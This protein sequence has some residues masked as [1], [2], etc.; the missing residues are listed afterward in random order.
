MNKYTSRVVIEN[1]TIMAYIDMDGNPVIGQPNFPGATTP[2]SSAEEAQSWVD[3]HTL[4][5]NTSW[6]NQEAARIARESQE[7]L[8]N[9][10]L[11]EIH[12]ML[13]Q[14]TNNN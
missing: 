9:Q 2:W 1:G 7:A 3:S 10:R 14:L 11:E 13:T 5:L 12:A 4:E 8:N 6:T